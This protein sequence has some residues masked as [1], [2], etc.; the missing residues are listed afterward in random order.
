MVQTMW[1]QS[2]EQLEVREM[3]SNPPRVLPE[4]TD[5]G[6]SVTYPV[7]FRYLDGPIQISEPQR[8]PLAARE[9]EADIHFAA[10]QKGA[11]MVFVGEIVIRELEIHDPET[12]EPI[13]FWRASCPVAF[14]TAEN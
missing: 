9:L 10:Q 2:S 5:D 11:S 13:R 3:P 1:M 7:D 14:V 12:W 6:E 8:G 4:P